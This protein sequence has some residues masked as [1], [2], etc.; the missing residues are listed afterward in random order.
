VLERIFVQTDEGGI[1]PSVEYLDLFGT[2]LSGGAVNERLA[3]R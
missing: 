3:P 1:L 2:A